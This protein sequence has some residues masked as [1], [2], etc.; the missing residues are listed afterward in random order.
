LCRVLL[1]CVLVLE[2]KNDPQVTKMTKKFEFIATQTIEKPPMKSFT[3]YANISSGKDLDT[4]AAD[5]GPSGLRDSEDI[6]L[7]SDSRA[8]TF[9]TESD[10]KLVAECDDDAGT[11]DE[12][13]MLQPKKEKLSEKFR[14]WQQ[15]ESKLY[16]DFNVQPAPQSASITPDSDVWQNLDEQPDVGHS[17]VPLTT[18]SDSGSLLIDVGGG[19]TS[20]EKEGE[21]A[22]LN[23]HER[24]TLDL[25]D[26]IL[27]RN[28][29]EDGKNDE[30][31]MFEDVLETSSKVSDV[32]DEDQD[33]DLSQ[34]VE[35]NWPDELAERPS[36]SQRFSEE[37]LTIDRVEPRI[38][39][40][41]AK[42]MSRDF[43]HEL[44][45]DNDKDVSL[46]EPATKEPLQ[47]TDSA[48]IPCSQP[49]P[50]IETRFESDVTEPEAHV[51]KAYRNIY[52]EL[53]I[54]ST[55]DAEMADERSLETA[56]SGHI[57]DE[58]HRHA[59]E[60]VFDRE[61]IQPQEHTVRTDL[62]RYEE[63]MTATDKDAEPSGEKSPKTTDSG[64]ILEGHHVPESESRFDREVTEPQEHAIKPDQLDYNKKVTEPQEHAIKP[65]QLDYNKQVNEPQEHAIKPDQLDYS[66]QLQ[67]SSRDVDALQQEVDTTVNSREL[68]TTDEIVVET[69]VTEV[70]TVLMHLGETGDISVMET[71]EVKT[72][73][74]MKETK[75]ILERD[76]VAVSHR[77]QSD[78]VPLSP[79]PSPAGSF[80]SKT[81]DRQSSSASLK[82]SNSV[83][84]LL[85]AD[86]AEPFSDTRPDVGVD[87]GLYV[88]ICPYEPETEDVM[89][90]HDGEFLEIL[91]DTAEDWWMVKKC[92]DGREG[93]VPAQY[94]RDKH[95]DDRMVEEEIAKQ[96]DQI[97]VDSSK[98]ISQHCC[99][100]IILEFIV[101]KCVVQSVVV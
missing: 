81:P 82:A 54:P 63:W 68:E 41:T 3:Y 34:M 72:D 25:S 18:E 64:D 52:E 60:A 17:Q 84:R 77:K 43:S 97:Y 47:T 40:S 83:D 90:L 14:K 55:K 76:E 21:P 50:V 66:K 89:S 7:S 32:K 10:G 26:D 8:P 61:V 101:E 24:E 13:D 99:Q 29:V 73:T 15:D 49:G 5:D 95:S 71:T 46:K 67:A 65:D 48:D 36:D 38:S 4:G 56:D 85:E 33:V 9:V 86:L 28:L 74:D 2:T 37:P 11:V 45:S 80:R 20:E 35:R 16:S 12:A 79:S 22:M 19:Q 57:P 87:A 98:K 42:R 30:Y 92:F 93:Y 88:A 31:D 53:M 6:E 27:Q 78:F 96:L 70:K 75:K 94:L 44:V 62:P 1:L 23:G 39:V 51:I 100:V 91:E 59:V 69:K 58:E